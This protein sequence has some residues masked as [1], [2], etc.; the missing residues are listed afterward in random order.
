MNFSGKT[1]INILLGQYHRYT[2]R[3]VQTKVQYRPFEF[4]F[5]EVSDL[6]W[7]EINQ[8]DA[9]RRPG[10]PPTLPMYTALWLFPQGPTYSIN[11]TKNVI[12]K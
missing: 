3:A 6:I 2:K 1:F 11:R 5:C 7:Y 4:V 9:L 12:R 10:I 8:Y